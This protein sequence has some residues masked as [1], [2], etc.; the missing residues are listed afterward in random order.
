MTDLAIAVASG[1][2]WRGYKAKATCGVV[3]FYRALAREFPDGETASLDHRS[4]RAKGG[5]RSDVAVLIVVSLVSGQ[6]TEKFN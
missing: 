1:Q 4:R 2:D 3:Y 6:T 5:R